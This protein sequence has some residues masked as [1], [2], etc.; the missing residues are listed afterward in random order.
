MTDPAKTSLRSR[1]G[2]D[3]LESGDGTGGGDGRSAESCQIVAIGMGDFL[4][5]AKQ[6]KTPESVRVFLLSPDLVGDS[7]IFWR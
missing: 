7:R 5:Q 4:D 2:W 1:H 3:D 6:A